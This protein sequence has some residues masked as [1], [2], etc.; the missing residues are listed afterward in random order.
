MSKNTRRA[1]LLGT[2]A[3]IGAWATRKYDVGDGPVGERLGVTGNLSGVLNDASE[4]SPTPTAKHLTIKDKIEASQIDFLRKELQDAK[5]ANR[6]AI[7]SA[8]RHSMG[9]QSMARAGTTITLDQEWVELDGANMTYRCG[10]GTRWSSV[11]KAL[12]VNGFSPAVM[13]SNNDF[14]VAATYSVNAH[15]WPVPFSGCGSTV[16]SLKMMLA[17]GEIINCS[18]VE[19]ADLFTAAMGGYGLFGIITEMEMQMVPNTRLAPTYT[20]INP[21]EFGPRFVSTINDN[22]G[23]Q[24]A[25]GRMDVS[26]DR[27]FERAMMITYRPTTDQSNLPA[28]SGPGLFSNQIR[29]VFRAQV[30]NDRAK[31]RRWWVETGLGPWVMGGDAT[32]NSLMNEPVIALDDQDPSRTD[33][34]H[35]Y[36]VAPEKFAAFVSACREVILSSY[37]DLLN[38]TL[39]YV[40]PDKESWLTY[41]PNDRIAAVM[42]FSQEKSRRAEEDMARMTEE[43][44]ER[45][46]AL[47]GSYYLPYRLHARQDQF[48]KAY[49]GIRPFTAKKRAM[50]PENLFRHA[51]WDKYMAKV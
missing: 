45:T 26:R 7:A 24:M 28:A 33:I 9:G 5:D 40:T 20:E 19:N 50:D 22:S 47:G 2:G 1:V 30:N 16:K 38:I 12:D 6:P 41:A 49:P 32:R 14:C 46:L 43:L 8:A 29:K 42:L 36:F 48:E 4:L 39:R 27:F 37:Q 17:T 34:L 51:L 11:I 35:E 10:A 18:R 15:G 31:H 21:M 3:L 13:Q 25:Y 23:V 44:I